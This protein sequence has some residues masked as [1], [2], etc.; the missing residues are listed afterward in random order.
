MMML[1]GMSVLL[2]TASLQIPV[3]EKRS[4][5]HPLKQSVRMR[6]RCFGVVLVNG[7]FD[8]FSM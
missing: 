3:L 6:L 5:A 1:I 7:Y 8:C 2:L 4:A